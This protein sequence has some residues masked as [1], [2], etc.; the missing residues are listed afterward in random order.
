L[1]CSA[2]TLFNT[3]FRLFPVGIVLKFKIPEFML[4]FYLVLNFSSDLFS[5]ARNYVCDLAVRVAGVGDVNL[6][7]SIYFL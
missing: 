6:F 3:L 1:A 4:G 2:S 7:L 5:L